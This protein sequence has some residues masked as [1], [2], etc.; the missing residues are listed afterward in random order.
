MNN[1]YLAM[2][3]R[4]ILGNETAADLAEL[5]NITPKAGDIYVLPK[6]GRMLYVEQDAGDSARGPLLQVLTPGSDLKAYKMN[7]GDT[8]R[9]DCLGSKEGWTRVSR[10]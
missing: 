3:E 6:T 1:D 8:F 10:G 4:F 5:D 2:I 9:S 7:V